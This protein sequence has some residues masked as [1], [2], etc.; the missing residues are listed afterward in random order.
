MGSSPVDASERL[1]A[2]QRDLL[3]A[4]F[5]LDRDFFLTGGAALVGFWIGHRHTDDLDLFTLDDEAFARGP[6]V[7]AAAAERVGASW[8]VRQDAPG[9]RRYVVTRGEETIVVDLVRERVAQRVAHKPER[10]GVR[11]DPP[12]EILANKLTTLVARQEERDLVDVYVL[13]TRFGL[14][15]EDALDAA[16]A[17]DGGCTPAT[18]AWLLSQIRIPATMRLPG[19]VD[20]TQLAE[21]LTEL[22]RRL[23]AA[24]H[25]AG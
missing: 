15:V 16:L 9:F 17:K 13:E 21:W 8:A 25:P 24:A 10:D 3:A 1:T 19:N 6:H 2:L 12:E 23:R 4:F 5:A 18:L 11:V 20:P 7:L 14:R 22:V